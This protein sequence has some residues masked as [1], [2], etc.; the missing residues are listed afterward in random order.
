M[1]NDGGFTYSATEGNAL[2]SRGI[3]ISNRQFHLITSLY[4]YALGNNQFV[5]EVPMVRMEKMK[6]TGRE[7]RRSCKIR[8]WTGGITFFRLGDAAV[9]VA[10]YADP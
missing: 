9:I 3:Y 4:D 2:C 8:R 10:R 6:M 1:V 7:I 5:H